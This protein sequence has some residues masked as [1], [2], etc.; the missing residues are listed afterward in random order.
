MAKTFI[1]H[2]DWRRSRRETE[3][4]SELKEAM[5][6]LPSRTGHFLLDMNTHSR[7]VKLGIAVGARHKVRVRDEEEGWGPRGPE[8]AFRF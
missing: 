1:R 7:F 2:E 5:Q 8:K 4:M 3:M 6:A